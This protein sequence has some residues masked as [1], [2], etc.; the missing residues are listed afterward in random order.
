MVMKVNQ[1]LSILF[2]LW[3]KKVTNDGRIPIYVRFTVNGARDGFASGRKINAEYWNEETGLAVKACPDHREINSYIIKTRADLE[4]HFNQLSATNERVT[5]KM[6]KDA[7]IPKVVAQN[8]LLEAFKLHNNE[9]EEKVSKKKGTK[10]TL[11][12]YERLKEKIV[13]FLLKKYKISDI[14]VVDI[15]LAFANNFYHYLI[16]NDI[17]G[18]TAMKYVKTLKQV[19]DRIIIEEWI[20]QNP[21]KGFK[22]TYKDPDRECLEMHE[23]MALYNKEIKIARLAEVRDV[24]LFCIFTGYAYETTYNL[25][26]ENIFTGLDGKLWITKNRGMT[27]AEETVPLLPVA[28]EIVN[29]YANH[30]YCVNQHKLLPV[31]SNYRYNVYLKELADICGITKNLTTH[32]ARHTFATTITLENDVPLETVGKMLGHKDSRST[33]IYAKITKRKISNNMN[34]LHGKL[35]DK[36]GKLKVPTV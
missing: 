21:L 11:A 24:Y 3:R 25:E 23:I 12:R 34:E 30:P 31:N 27:G 15:K 2:W 1:N 10:G 7:Y 33:Q 16:M 32:T 17:G 13:A 14:P 6:L 9:F 26:P 29:K 4:R 36:S 19:I 8:T 28:L 18:N 20:P 22:C 5:V 35:F